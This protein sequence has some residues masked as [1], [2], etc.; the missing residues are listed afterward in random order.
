MLILAVPVERSGSVPAGSPPISNFLLQQTS[1]KPIGSYWT[2]TLQV[3]NIVFFVQ[4]LF[5]QEQIVHLLDC[6]F[7]A[8][9][10][11]KNI[12]FIVFEALW[13]RISHMCKLNPLNIVFW[14]LKKIIGILLV[15]KHT[16]D[17]KSTLTC[18]DRL[19]NAHVSK[20]LLICTSA[21][22]S[23]SYP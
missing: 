22:Q 9:K 20:Q 19:Y 2:T 10:W 13:N 1:L 4:T 12:F 3:T 15:G 17:A 18:H 8:D 6:F 16:R 7:V 5:K 23:C 11:R 14:C 21:N